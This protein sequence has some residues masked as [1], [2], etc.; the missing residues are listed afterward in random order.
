[1]EVILQEEI[2]SLGRIGDVVNVAPGYANNYL[3]PKGLAIVATPGNLKQLEA[4][5]TI[6]DKKESAVK[7]EAEKIAAKVDG[8]DI[9]LEAR[10]GEE[11]RLY[12]SVTAKD[13][14]EAIGEQLKVEV[15]KNQVGLGDHIKDAGTHEI[16]I[17]F[18]F[19]VDAIIKAEIVAI[20]E[21]S[22]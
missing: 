5:R 20:E 4:R 8:K 12:G 18:H 6:I 11:G 19:D 21:K 16:K 2:L 22:R 7:K 14:A 13:I 15:D 1:M 3:I 10:A 17:K 9:K